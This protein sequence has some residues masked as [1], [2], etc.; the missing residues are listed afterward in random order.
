M[1]SLLAYI[2][3]VHPINFFQDWWWVLLLPLSFGIAVI[4]K[5]MR[6]EKLSRYWRQVAVLTVQIV[7]GMIGLALALMVLVQW[8][9]P[10]LPVDNGN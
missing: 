3:F 6:V 8:V 4:Y 5:A 1:S 9:I 7:L 10:L 2:P